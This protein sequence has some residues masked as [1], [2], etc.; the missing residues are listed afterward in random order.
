M[1]ARTTV[2]EIPSRQTTAPA[3]GI[4]LVVSIRNPASLS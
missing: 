4:D 2:K 3:W 1:A